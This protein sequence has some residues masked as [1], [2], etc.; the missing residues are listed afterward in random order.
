MNGEEVVPLT[1]LKP[2][3]KWRAYYQ[4]QKSLRFNNL[5]PFSL[6]GKVVRGIATGAN[7]YFMFS[8]LKAQKYNIPETCLLPCISRSN[9]VKNSFFTRTLFDELVLQDK[10]VFLLDVK[11]SNDKNVKMY[12]ELGIQEGVHE[13]YLTSKRNPWFSI[14]NRPPSPI[15]VSVFNRN[16]LRFI[17]NEANISNLTTFHCIYPTLSSIS[18]PELFFAYLLTSVAIDI[19][20]DNRREYGN[21][22]QKF[23]P[24]DLNKGNMLNLAALNTATIKRIVQLYNEYRNSEIYGFPEERCLFELDNIFIENFT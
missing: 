6:Y 21:G 3:I 13:I 23:E 20:N 14:E 18:N 17:R 19:F 7:D 11:G 4:E 16:G 2:D 12:I 10:N 5:V 8:K 22:L 9:D 24:N 15:W 1:H